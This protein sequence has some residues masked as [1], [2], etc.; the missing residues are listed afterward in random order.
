MTL[1]ALDFPDLY[2]M[3]SLFALMPNLLDPLFLPVVDMESCLLVFRDLRFE[4]DLIF[5]RCF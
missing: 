4:G 2:A 1:D 3:D 5:E